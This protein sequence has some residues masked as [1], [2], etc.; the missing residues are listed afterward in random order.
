[1]PFVSNNP[2]LAWYTTQKNP[3]HADESVATGNYHRSFWPCMLQ[4]Y[5]LSSRRILPSLN[6]FH[7]LFIFEKNG[8]VEYLPIPFLFAQNSRSVVYRSF[9][10][11]IVYA[12][13][14]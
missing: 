4:T 5:S 2:I 10:N 9:A 12:Y 6:S 7:L 1:M 11:Q 14:Y 13:W 8:F 3:L